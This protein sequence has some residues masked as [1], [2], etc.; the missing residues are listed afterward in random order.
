MRLDQPTLGTPIWFDLSTPNL[1]AARAFYSAVLGWT[2]QVGGPEFGHY[3]NAFIG[4]ATVAGAGPMPPNAPVSA[5][6]VYFGVASADEAAGRIAE[7]GGQVLMPPMDVGP[8]GRMAIA[9]D[10][11]GAVF[12][13]WQPGTHAGRQVADEP[14]AVCWSEVN[15]R[16]GEAARAFYSG[17]FGLNTSKMPGGGT[18][19][20]MM[21]TAEQGPCCGVLQM[22]AQW[23]EI[24]PHWMVYFAVEDTEAAVERVRAAG[25]TVHVAPFDTPPGRMAVVGDPLGAVFSV[26]RVN[27]DFVPPEG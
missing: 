3:S 24:P 18:E 10:P 7:H 23:G 14:G 2:W 1:E 13:L 21:G 8:F 9:Q 19:Y 20:W 6:M 17:V 5:W 4:D 26:I 15:T 12:G 25:G 22:N 11:T 27:P 16:G